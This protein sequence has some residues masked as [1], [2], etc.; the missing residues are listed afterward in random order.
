MALQELAPIIFYD[1][2]ERELAPE[3]YRP[4]QVPDA[5]LVYDLA[6]DSGLSPTT[7]WRRCFANG[8]NEFVFILVNQDYTSLVVEQTGF[9]LWDVD[10]GAG[11]YHCPY[12]AFWAAEVA[13]DWYTDPNHQS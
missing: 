1:H 2:Y 13:L 12:D 7:G 8:A 3:A 9:G 5:P 6:I 4:H 10:A 11:R